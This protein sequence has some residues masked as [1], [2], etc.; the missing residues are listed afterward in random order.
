MA[1]PYFSGDGRDAS[2]RILAR[3]SAQRL[4]LRHPDLGYSILYSAASYVLRDKRS[5]RDSAVLEEA[6]RRK[7]HVLRATERRPVE[8]ADPAY[9]RPCRSE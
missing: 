9:D 2:Y 8:P 5:A 4:A 1:T 6:R 3:R 7:E